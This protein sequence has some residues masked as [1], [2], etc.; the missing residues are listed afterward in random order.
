MGLVPPT[1]DSAPPFL[2]SDEFDKLKSEPIKIIKRATEYMA[3]L[4]K[5]YSIIKQ[6]NI[7][8]QKQIDANNLS[9]HSMVNN[10]IDIVSQASKSE[11]NTKNAKSEI[12]QKQLNIKRLQAV[13]ST[14]NSDIE[15]IQ[16]DTDNQI[17]RHEEL[18][19]ENNEITASLS[20]WK[21]KIKSKEIKIKNIQTE[22]Q[23]LVDKDA[24][25][26]QKYNS[27]TSKMMELK[28]THEKLESGK[29]AL[30]AEVSA[31]KHIVAQ[32]DQTFNY[33]KEE[34]SILTMTLSSR[35]NELASLKKQTSTDTMDLQSKIAEFEEKINICNQKMHSEKNIVGKQNLALAKEL[36]EN[37]EEILA[38]RHSMT[39]ESTD[40]HEE[41]AEQR[42]KASLLMHNFKI[43]QIQNELRT[44]EHKRKEVEMETIQYSYNLRREIYIQK[45]EDSKKAQIKIKENISQLQEELNDIKSKL[46]QK[47]LL[48]SK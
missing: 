21:D 36:R 2:T 6:Q 38:L 45:T 28:R 17:K 47:C 20:E 29:I 41:L 39:K 11:T 23:E 33:L 10:N 5:Q 30:E 3:L 35:I 9:D 48:H 42:V 27:L 18:Q 24:L 34:K 7:D 22:I 25:V 19:S 44:D 37:Q 12:K 14:L 4:E 43:L 8:L 13:L 16:T 46:C 26:V 31:L 15:Y 32:Q 1:H 40:Q